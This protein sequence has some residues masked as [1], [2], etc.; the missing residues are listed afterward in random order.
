MANECLA[1]VAAGRFEA[2]RQLG[3][4]LVAQDPLGSDAL[5]G[6]QYLENVAEMYVAVG[7]HDAAIDL[8]DRLLSLPSEMSGMSVGLDPTWAP[9]RSNPRFHALLERYGN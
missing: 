3:E 5:Y 2:A 6:P 1:Q 9:L 7:E 8:L 4:E